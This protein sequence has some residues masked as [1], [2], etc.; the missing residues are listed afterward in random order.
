MNAG[1]E[2]T[3]TFDNVGGSAAD[4]ELAVT[5]GIVECL[6]SEAVNNNRLTAVFKALEV[7]DTEILA[8]A[9]DKEKRCAVHV[10]PATGIRGTL[11]ESNLPQLTYSDCTLHCDGQSISLYTLDGRLAATARGRMSLSPFK[12]GIYVAK[13][14]GQTLKIVVNGR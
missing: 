7:G 8:K 5:G 10:L 1:D 11:S 6:S 2:F 3:L 12:S 14:A 4:I 13:A 9:H